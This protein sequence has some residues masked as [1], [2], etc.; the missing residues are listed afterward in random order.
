MFF[1]ARGPR[2]SFLDRARAPQREPPRASLTPPPH[3]PS[4]RVFV[5]SQGLERLATVVPRVV[6]RARSAVADGGRP[7]GR[8]DDPLLRR[9]LASKV[10]ALRALRR[11]RAAPGGGAS[12]ARLSTT[13]RA[14]LGNRPAVTDRPVAEED[15]AGGAAGKLKK[16]VEEE[17]N[18][19]EKAAAGRAGSVSEL[20]NSAVAS[21]PLDRAASIGADRK[22]AAPG[23]GVGAPPP[24]EAMGASPSRRD[25]RRVFGTDARFVRA[26]LPPRGGRGGDSRERRSRVRVRRREGSR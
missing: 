14:I 2:G 17:K 11:K 13:P 23:G 8:S 1:R 15:A 4:R 7:R 26:S 16:D 12:A 25:S 5:S 20:A 19:N 18:K 3:L 22:P 6:P 21:P 9:A 10:D 24:G